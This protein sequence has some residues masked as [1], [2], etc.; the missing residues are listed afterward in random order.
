[1]GE[2][3]NF[4]E[5]EVKINKNQHI[6]DREKSVKRRSNM[7]NKIIDFAPA[8]L[9]CSL[10]DD[11]NYT[12]VG[13]YI[14]RG[15]GSPEGV[16]CGYG[17]VG[18]RLVFAFAQDE[19]KLSG[20]LD[21]CAV[22]KL[23][24]LYS[25]AL[26]SGA[27]VVGIFSSSGAVVS[28][29]AELLG[30]LGSL[31]STFA[32]ASGEIPQIALIAGVCTGASAIAASMFDVVVAL[33]GAEF[34]HAP[35]FIGGAQDPARLGLCAIV[36]ESKQDLLAKGRALVEAL[37]DSSD[38]TPDLSDGYDL[39]REFAA[40]KN[41][42]ASLVSAMSDNGESIELYSSVGR[43][44]ITALAPVGGAYI[45]V[46][47]SNHNENNG[48]ITPEGAVKAAKL[49]GLC[50]DFSI[51]VVSLLNSDGVEMSKDTDERG[52]AQAAAD[53]AKAYRYCNSAKVNAVVGRA[54]GSVLPIFSGADVTFAASDAVIS[55]LT[56]EKAVAF[57]RND[58]IAPGISREALEAEYARVDASPVNAASDGSIDFVCESGEL[59]ARICG[60]LM[61]LCPD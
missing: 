58:E 4:P 27:P 51:P 42:G 28:E 20:A 35:E 15:V 26:K 46:I 36:A 49:I 19:T 57:L 40:D 25:L 17:P 61:M 5:T 43:E 3:L 8:E 2:K 32:M 11:G 48:L 30:A 14:K 37:P 56:P 38:Y 10:F 52:A 59:R 13:A 33:G 53:L 39:D 54:C 44:L 18:G 41:D 45:G 24:N 47:A 55:P 22:K 29:G 7:S 34:S 6:Y 21:A 23:E 16:A 12:E 60:A 50:S 31:Y 9:L 1:M